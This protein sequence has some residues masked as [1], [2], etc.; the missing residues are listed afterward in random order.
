MGEIVSPDS[1]M[2]SL[3]SKSISHV[4]VDRIVKSIVAGELSPGDKLPPEDDFAERIGVGKSSVRE[5]IKILEAFGV[6]EIRRA[7]GTYVVDEFRGNMLSPLISGM[8]IAQKN[9]VDVIDFKVRVQRIALDELVSGEGAHHDALYK[10]LSRR[11]SKNA[12]ARTEET[13]RLLDDVEMEL[14]GAVRNPLVAELYLRSTQLSSF[15]IKRTIE[16]DASGNRLT[17]LV[18]AWQ[19]V[20]QALVEQDEYALKSALDCECAVLLGGVNG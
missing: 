10:D 5:A 16:A 3:K 11:L 19:L 2:G 14:S 6:I 4:I 20:L 15:E 9:A 1:L 7:D 13:L 17:S 18:G 8:L 12:A